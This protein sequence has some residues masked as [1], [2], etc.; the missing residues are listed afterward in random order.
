MVIKQAELLQKSG[1]YQIL[2]TVN[3][4]MYIGSTSMS[5]QKRYAHHVAMLRCGRHKNNYLQYAFNKYKEDNFEFNI[6]EL[7]DKAHVLE[8]EEY[9]MNKLLTNENSYNI[10]K[11]ASGGNQFSEETIKRRTESIK[12]YWKIN[13]TDKLKG[14]VPWNKGKHYKSTNHLKV[15][16]R[17]KGDRSKDIITKRNNA[18]EVE[19]YDENM[20]F[21]GKWRSAKD[22]QEW[23]LTDKNNLPIKSRFKQSRMN[24]PISYLSAFHINRSSNL[25]KPYKGLYF[26][27]ITSPS[28][29]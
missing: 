3:G 2:N 16:K 9:W 13:G 20:K 29:E 21:I 15:P 6:L 17:V 4:K 28:T 14:K 25:N 11:L 23:S 24:K 22:L 19:V 5:F 1:V 10:N 12:R 27:L 18:P 7:C 8:K 26:K